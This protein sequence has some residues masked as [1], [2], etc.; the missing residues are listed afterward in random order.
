MNAARMQLDAVLPIAIGTASTSASLSSLSAGETFSQ[1]LASECDP[2]VITESGSRAGDTIEVPAPQD[3]SGADC[4][5]VQSGWILR[6][7][8]TP[9]PADAVPTQAEDPLGLEQGPNAKRGPTSQGRATSPISVLRRRS[10][11]AEGTEPGP[12]GIVGKSANPPGTGSSSETQLAVSSGVSESI[13][14]PCAAESSEDAEDPRGINASRQDDSQI[15]QPVVGVPLPVVHLNDPN[16]SKLDWAGASD[17][18]GTTPDCD[19]AGHLLT[20][21]RPNFSGAA[22]PPVAIASDRAA[23]DT[24]LPGSADLK[25]SLIVAS[26][27][28]SA[29]TR[30]PGGLAPVENPLRMGIPGKGEESDQQFAQAEN[31]PGT[32]IPKKGIP[33]TVERSALTDAPID[34]QRASRIGP[35]WD[36]ERPEVARSEHFAAAPVSRAVADEPELR[37]QV[38]PVMSLGDGRS[39]RSTGGSVAAVPPIAGGDTISDAAAGSEGLLRSRSGRIS[40]DASTPRNASV[41]VDVGTLEAALRRGIQTSEERRDSSPIRRTGRPA[42]VEGMPHLGAEDPVSGMPGTPLGSEAGVESPARRKRVETG[43]P[44]EAQVQESP[45]G[46]T[47]PRIEIREVAGGT[48]PPVPSGEGESWRR[49]SSRLLQA[50]DGSPKRDVVSASRPSETPSLPELTGNHRVRWSSTPG[51]SEPAVTFEDPSQPPVARRPENRDTDH[52]PTRPDDRS[53]APV[54]STS[55]SPRGLGVQETPPAPSVPSARSAAVVD[56]L[57]ADVR[58][59]VG[60]A[61]M[62]PSTAGAVGESLDRRPSARLQ[63]LSQRASTPGW[64]IRKALDGTRTAD[65]ESY[66]LLESPSG[67]PADPEAQE[68]PPSRVAAALSARGSLRSQNS[69]PAHRVQSSPARMEPESAS[70]VVAGGPAENGVGSGLRA[71]TSAVAGGSPASSQSPYTTGRRDP[72][73]P[74]PSGASTAAFAI[75]QETTESHYE[76]QSTESQPPSPRPSVTGEAPRPTSHQVELETVGQGRLQLRMTETGSE[77]RIEAREVGNALS[78]TEGGWQDLQSRLGESGVVLGPLQS[79]DSQPDFRRDQTPPE[80]RH[81]VCY[82]SSQSESNRQRDPSG[83]QTRGG[84][85]PFSN[86]SPNPLPESVSDPIAEGPPARRRQGREWWA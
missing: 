40:I 62:R 8:P 12:L 43:F 36:S 34:P 45:S 26:I 22:A 79:G 29:E 47:L 35:R 32:G 49:A 50:I 66:P 83:F 82:D 13:P 74:E 10:S 57:P 21:Q 7:R 17:V 78:G 51:A 65:P 15:L 20:V 71:S 69:R 16:L 75:R 72:G 37:S 33:T 53:A 1:L 31:S 77:I 41:P 3:A 76:V 14:A 46:P 48:P 9:I 27:P 6:P 73:V 24:S 52:G 80:P 25:R 85:T 30:S 18:E 11:G 64:E 59:S 56:A 19:A 23:M 58:E 28:L 68:I 70:H 54:E 38:I 44:A 60:V 86:P 67:S 63:G 42:R 39:T 55:G 61:V 2:G 5:A 4:P 84:G 81:A